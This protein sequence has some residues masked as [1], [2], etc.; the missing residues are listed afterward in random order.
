MDISKN[1]KR[2]LLILIALGLVAVLV[3]PGIYAYFSS[4]VT[5]P[6]NL[7]TAGTIEM[8]VDNANPWTGTF[9]AALT[10]L[11]PAMKGW[12]NVTLYNT[13]TNPFDVWV[14]IDNVATAAGTET[15]PE[16]AEPAA[17][18]IDSVMRYGLNVGGVSKIADAANIFIGTPAHGLTGTAMKTNWIYLGNIAKAGTLKVDQSFMMDSSTTNWAQGDTM[19]FTVVFYAQQSEGTPK[20]TAPTPELPGYLRP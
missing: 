1:K 14:K 13:G 3:G 12:G 6:A 4:T 10:D 19:G 18:D 5:S 8:K 2:S 15:I 7:F 16:A 17:T 9:T 11:K 20:P